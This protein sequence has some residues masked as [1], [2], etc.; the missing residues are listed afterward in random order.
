MPLG[1]L[2]KKVRLVLVLL[3]GVA[4][5]A[6]GLPAVELG[7]G[8]GTFVPLQDGESVPIVRG[9]QGAQHIWAQ[10]R[11][12]ERVDGRVEI[13]FRLEEV[14]TGEEI[15]HNRFEV[16]LIGLRDGGV[17]SGGAFGRPGTYAFV[18]EPERIDGR[19]VRLVGW[20]ESVDGVRTSDSR[21]VNPVDETG[22]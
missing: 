20:V 1:F 4:G 9:F 3:A 16:E 2:K 22:R 13:G 11:L 6:P 17:A 8:H 18:P 21:R 7:T 19:E 15:H 5:C 14:D 10:V 12:L